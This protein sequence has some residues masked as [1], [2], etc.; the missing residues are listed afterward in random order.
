MF[1][2]V[3]AALATGPNRYARTAL[4]TLESIE[5]KDP[6][7]L[8]VVVTAIVAIIALVFC[9][10]GVF[11]L[12]RLQA[13]AKNLDE[14][15]AE[16][17]MIYHQSRKR[18]LG[19]IGVTAPLLFISGVAWTGAF[20]NPQ[21]KV[22]SAITNAK[23]SINEVDYTS[24]EEALSDGFDACNGEVVFFQMRCSD[25]LMAQSELMIARAY[26]ALDQDQ[27]DAFTSTLKAA[28]E[29]I[30]RDPDAYEGD[31]KRLQSQVDSIDSVLAYHHLDKG[32][33]K[34]AATLLE[35]V[36]DTEAAIGAYAKLENKEKVCE[37]GSE[38]LEPN[39]TMNACLELGKLERAASI[40]SSMPKEEV[41]PLLDKL[42][43]E[44]KWKLLCNLRYQLDDPAKIVEACLP[45]KRYD[46]ILVALAMIE[47]NDAAAELLANL[48]KQGEKALV[49]KYGGSDL[50]AELALAACKEVKNHSKTCMI[51]RNSERAEECVALM[52]ELADAEQFDSVCTI[53]DED[54]EPL[55]TAN[56]CESAK[57]YELAFS[58][59]EHLE[60]RDR[61][62]GLLKRLVADGESELACDLGSS[63]VAPRL[64]A[65]ACADS[66]ELGAALA[67][68]GAQEDPKGSASLLDR[69]LEK[70]HHKQVCILGSNE[71][72]PRATA[73]A[74]E[75]QGR[76]R[77][78]AMLY[79]AAGE[80]TQLD[81]ILS[82]E[83]AENRAGAVCDW[84]ADGIRSKLAGQACE[85][86]GELAEAAKIYAEAGAYADAGRLFEALSKQHTSLTYLLEGARAYDK[87][88][89]RKK[90]IALYERALPTVTEYRAV[91]QYVEIMRARG[92]LEA[93]L[94]EV[95]GWM[96]EAEKAGEYHVLLGLMLRFKNSVITMQ[97]QAPLS[98]REFNAILKK[99]IALEAR[100]DRAIK[101][102]ERYPE[103]KVEAFGVSSGENALFYDYIKSEGVLQNKSDRDIKSI[104]LVLEFFEPANPGLPEGVEQEH[105]GEDD[106]VLFPRAGL[107]HEVV[108][109]NIPAGGS[110]SFFT[111]VSTI[112]PYK[113]FNHYFKKLEFVE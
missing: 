24:A 46:D 67:I 28:R 65:D 1:A 44:K 62:V 96:D 10:A 45:E 63:E 4:R 69:A 60:E 22:A 85:K 47:A 75:Q 97:A 101:E 36:G 14:M 99:M 21:Y 33:V 23:A 112:T 37:L 8:E 106:K 64:T 29:N 78:A 54:F 100:V 7:D 109:R 42:R 73:K 77:R 31:I 81:R 87:S 59:F 51:L 35:K 107:K 90:A 38:D 94:E 74:C 30:D 103:G 84:T 16:E 89:D 61:S 111:T 66:G 40:G 76:V 72:N 79:H 82:K 86:V 95:K 57:N 5:L 49:C 53:G 91:E 17:D 20:G 15:N 102:I 3:S 110:Q 13:N 80:T 50:A 41:K 70:G 108:I 52:K 2:Y 39:R 19:L 43:A 9:G 25:L 48:D 71:L 83:I 32:R 27:I 58:L 18:Y 56:A 98:N 113:S 88:G 6:G 92:E 12:V 68:L 11:A 105:T 93:A 34:D 26:D 104:V 55:L